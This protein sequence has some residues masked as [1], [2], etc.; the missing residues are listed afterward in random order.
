MTEDQ[1]LVR[2][3]GK[4]INED[5]L[6]FPVDRQ[7]DCSQLFQAKDYKTLRPGEGAIE[8]R[9]LAALQLHYENLPEAFNF[10]PG[11]YEDKMHVLRIDGNG[12]IKVAASFV[13]V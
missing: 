3:Y 13:I 8:T 7:L 6:R 10:V 9:R 5:R 1:A 4:V 12:Y 11:F 2:E